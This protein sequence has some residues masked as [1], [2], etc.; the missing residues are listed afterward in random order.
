MEKRFEKAFLFFIGSEIYMPSVAL[1]AFLTGCEFALS[2]ERAEANPLGF[3]V[4]EADVASARYS[5][6]LD[7]AILK[8]WPAIGAMIINIS[9]N[10]ASI[11]EPESE[12]ESRRLLA[13]PHQSERENISEMMMTAP[14]M[15]DATV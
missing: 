7:N 11:P 13:P 15:T 14:I 12:S 4:S 9:P 10:S 2:F 1:L 3:P 8:S 6:F 5:L